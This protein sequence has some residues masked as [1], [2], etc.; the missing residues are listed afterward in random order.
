[1]LDLEAGV[2]LHEEEIAMLIEDKFHRPGVGVPGLAGQGAGHVAQ[3]LTQGRI[4]RR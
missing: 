2:H 4:N 1:M 3:P